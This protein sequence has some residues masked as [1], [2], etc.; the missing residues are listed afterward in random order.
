M[1]KEINDLRVEL[2][3]SRSLAHDLDT[4]L[5][6]ARKQGFDDQEAIASSKPIIPVTGL[7]NV[8]PPSDNS[9]IIEMQR[10]EIS[11]LRGKLRELE[12]LQR[13]LSGSKLPP[14]HPIAPVSVQQ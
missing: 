8:E 9:R 10:L 1:L 3:K 7:A 4:A 14:M 12:G 5:N 6:I 13:P 2:K 11:R